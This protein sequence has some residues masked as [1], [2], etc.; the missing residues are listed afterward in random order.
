[1][2]GTFDFSRSA[3]R[4]TKS[5]AMMLLLAL[6]CIVAS[7]NSIAQTATPG[8]LRLQGL[9]EC[10]TFYQNNLKPNQIVAIQTEMNQLQNQ[11]DAQMIAPLPS[12]QFQ[13][14]LI[15]HSG[16]ELVQRY[17]KQEAVVLEPAYFEG[18]NYEQS[19]I[20]NLAQQLAHTKA[21]I[22]LNY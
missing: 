10:F 21:E 5:F 12:S 1:M 18:A 14:Y 7:L 8:Q 13:A 6:F 3:P 19:N 20:D 22:I 11:L 16:D 2:K 15:S 17:I 4:T 9:Q